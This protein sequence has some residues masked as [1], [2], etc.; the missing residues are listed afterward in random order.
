MEIGKIATAGI[1][2]FLPLDGT[3][4]SITKPG[5]THHLIL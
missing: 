5:S 3:S 2:Y 1:S 4:D